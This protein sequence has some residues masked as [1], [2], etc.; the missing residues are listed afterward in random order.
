[1]DASRA[2]TTGTI[3]FSAP[4]QVCGKPIDAQPLFSQ[5]CLTERA[6]TRPL[7]DNEKEFPHGTPS[8]ID[9]MRKH[10]SLH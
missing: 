6:W 1:M 10:R 7:S 3:P 5:T 9:C 8:N 2:M 4:R